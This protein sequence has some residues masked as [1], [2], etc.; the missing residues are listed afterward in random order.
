MVKGF[1]ETP[2]DATTGTTTRTTGTNNSGNSSNGDD[3]IIDTA[4]YEKQLQKQVNNPDGSIDY[5]GIVPGLIEFEKYRNAVDT[6]SKNT[7]LLHQ[8]PVTLTD[9]DRQ[10]SPLQDVYGIRR[11]KEK[12]AEQLLN[13]SRYISA[14][15]S[16]NS[17]AQLE[18][19]NKIANLEV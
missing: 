10:V 4:L 11:N 6:V 2:E 18:A 5:A 7:D 13:N 8:T 1:N 12:A 9:P 14:N 15:S 17:A 19:A 16:L 3:Y